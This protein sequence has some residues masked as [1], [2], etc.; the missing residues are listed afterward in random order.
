MSCCLHR[1]DGVDPGGVAPPPHQEIRISGLTAATP[2]GTTDTTVI[3]FTGGVVDLG[4]IAAATWVTVATTAA[5]GTTFTILESG[6][7]QVLLYIPILASWNA[8]ITLNATAAQLATI[9]TEPNANT[10]YGGAFEVTA[11]N[12]YNIP[13][14]HPVIPVTQAD[15]DAGGGRNVIRCHVTDVTTPGTPP[16]AGAFVNAAAVTCRILKTGEITG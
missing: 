12:A 5:N 10:A 6:F 4:V 11:P 7:Y 16:A 13:P 1:V 8:G 14:F 15:V 2:V 9:N 3:A